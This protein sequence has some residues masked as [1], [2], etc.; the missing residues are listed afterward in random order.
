MLILLIL[1]GVVSALVSGLL[2]R[3]EGSARRYGISMPQ[4]FHA[5]HVPR[6]GGVA[7]VAAFT[8]GLMW[9][10]VAERLIGT[11]HQINISP[12]AAMAWWISAAIAVAG[13][14]VEDVTHQ[15]HASWR[16]FMT[17]VAGIFATWSMGL[18]IQSLG[19]D[20]IQPLWAATPWPGL[21]LAIFAVAGLPHAFNLIDGYNGLAGIVALICSLALAYVS[22]LVGDRQLAAIAVVLAGSTSGFLLWNYPRGLIFA[23]DGGAYLWG[24]IIAISSVQ[25]VQRHPSVSP[26]FPVLLLIYPVWETVFSIYRKLARGQSPGVADALHFHQL[27]YRRI[28]RGVFDVDDEARRMLMRNNRTSPYLW[29]FTILTV[30]PAVLFWNKTHVL[31]FFAALF[32]VSYVWAYV[33]IVRFKVPRWLRR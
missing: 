22:L 6:L 12:T 33:S 31:M 16:L 19:I 11:S 28:V 24:A 15:V 10:V 27:I 17:V 26:W 32:V 4:R 18:S 25:L 30:I 5:G 23:G 7:M 8:L 9:I 1:C 2:L 14:V 29:G 20:F 21:A 3:Y 13:G